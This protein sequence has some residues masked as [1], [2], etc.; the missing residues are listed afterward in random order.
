MI[1]RIQKL[2]GFKTKETEETLSVVDVINN[3]FDDLD[4]DVIWL[5]IGSDIVPFGDYL[6]K[7]IIANLRDE[8]KYECGFILPPIHVT[9]NTS[10]QENEFTITI[11]GNLIENGYL[12]PTKTGIQDELYETL[13]T[14][15]YN[16]I[17]IIFTNEIA[18][19][20]IETV[21]RKNGWLIWN[22]TNQL[23]VI[24]IKTILIDIIN[25]GKSINN[26][27]YIFEQIGNQILT[28]GEY[29]DCLKKYNP[30]KI[31]NQIA[32]CL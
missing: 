18:E 8:I 15:V 22:L 23:S 27:T 13:K 19:K 7:D 5:Q 24:D 26:I 25:S 14:A 10:Y 20:Y 31:A 6:C 1:K 32:R 2:F 16:N 28:N 30:H 9:D 12:I 3:L 17:N 21:Q 29:R 11:R 4:G